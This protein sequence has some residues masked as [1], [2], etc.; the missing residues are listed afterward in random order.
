MPGEEFA[1]EC[2]CGHV[3]YSNVIPNECPKCLAIDS[4]TQLPEELMNER[5][6]EKILDEEL[7]MPELKSKSSKS[8]K[9]K[10]K[11]PDKPRRKKRR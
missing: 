2:E 11:K 1:W 5:E 7:E 8:G 6:K 10:L 9:P 3:E 4:F